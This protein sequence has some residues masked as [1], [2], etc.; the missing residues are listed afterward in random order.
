M[1]HYFR[2]L[3]ARERS[4][5][6]DRHL[7]WFLTFIAGAA[8]AGGFMAVQ[9]YTSHMSGIVSAMADNLV[10]GNLSL[11]LAGL[12]AFLSFVAGAAV[13]AILVNWG[14]RARATSE[15]ALPLL[16]ESL[17]L[18]L[19]GLLGPLL[20]PHVLLV[21]PATVSLL[22]FIMGLQNAM[23]TK[24][25]QARIRTTHITGLV[26]DMGIEIGK[27]LYVNTDERLAPVRADGAKLALL[28][29]LVGLF[30]AGGVFGAL[31]FR[32][33]GF[34]AAILLAVLVALLA[35][36]PVLDDARH[37]IGRGGKSAR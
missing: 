29:S 14:R 20:D 35:V 16:L 22:C 36:L 26:T 24:L 12:G 33:I 8:N 19:F 27:A 37:L 34:P 10:L 3:T 5:R 18:L 15:Y 30:F 17:L 2:Q 1:I 28:A 7:A 11:V 13:S 6:T 9:Q 25:S 31:A 4:E 23:I 21:V 32:S